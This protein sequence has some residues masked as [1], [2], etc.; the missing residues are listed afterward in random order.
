M[1]RPVSPPM[2]RLVQVLLRPD[3]ETL[4]LCEDHLTQE[5]LLRV[6]PKQQLHLLPN[7]LRDRAFRF[8]IHQSLS[9]SGQTRMDNF[10]R[11]WDHG[12]FKGDVE[13][14]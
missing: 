11:T 4:Q 7:V 13:G 9:P 5:I 14:T 10:L 3:I 12:L 8:Q 2:R 6:G 1:A